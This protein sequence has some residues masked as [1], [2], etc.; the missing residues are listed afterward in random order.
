MTRQDMVE[1]LIALSDEAAQRQFLRD[2]PSL[3]NDQV[4]AALKEQAD[5][6]IRADL[7]R[8]LQVADL[9]LYLGELSGNPLHRALGL[10]AM[11][12]ARSFGG[13]GEYEYAVQLL[14]EAT[15]IY[16][17]SNLP[18][19]EA[20]TQ[21]GKIWSLALLGRYDEAFATGQWASQIL[22]EHEEWL[23]LAKMTSNLGMI[24]YRLGQD[25]EALAMFDKAKALYERLGPEEAAERALARVEQ[26]RSMALRNLGQFD[27][28]VQTSQAALDMLTRTGQSADAA[29]ARQNLGITYFVLG[30]YNEALELLDQARDF[31]IADGR[32]R[33]AILIELFTSDCLLQIRRFDDVLAKCRQVR[34]RFSELGTRF[35]V[36]QAV[37]NEALAHA[38]LGQ[39]AE[40][41]A[42][43]DQARVLFEEEGNDVWVALVD[44]EAAALLCHQGQPGQGLRSAQS[45]ARVF[46]AH[47]LPTERARAYL[48][49]AQAFAALEERDRARELV[50]ESLA[51]IEG[52]DMPSLT[53]QCH[54]LLGNLAAGVRDAQQALEEYDQAIR[55]LERLRG[56][57]MVE[58]R[59]DFL[60]DKEAIYE[61]VVGLCLDLDMPQRSLEYAE[62]AKSRALLDLLTYRLDLGIRARR[63]EDHPLVEELVRLR[64]E[65][66]RLYRRWE[67]NEEQRVRGQITPDQGPGE[68]KQDV[69]ALEK[70]IT[71]LWH[72]L[73]VHNADYA[74]DAALW[75]VRT[76]PIQ[77]YLSPE[78]VLIEYFCVHGEFVAFTVTQDSVRAW[79]L[80][81][82]LAHIQQLVRLLWLNLRAVP[83]GDAN[84]AASLEANARGL[85][86]NLY[87]SLLAPLEKVLAQYAQWIV[88]PHGPLH[89]LPFHALHDGEAYV[90]ERHE[91]SYL[92]GASMLRY[93]REVQPAPSGT[94]VLGCSYEGRLPYTVHEARAIAAVLGER[95]CL[96]GEA[97]LDRLRSDAGACRALHLATHGEFRP[98]NPL[99][100]GLALADGWLTTLDIFNLRLRASL[101]TLSACQSGQS[102]VGGGDELQG[103]MRAFLYAG[104]ASLV[105]SLWAVEDRSTAQL[106]ET[107]Y[108]RLAEGWSKGAALR[109]AQRQF[110][111]DGSNQSDATL[112]HRGH[113]F[114]WAP[115]FLVGDTR[116]L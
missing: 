50:S 113:P 76:E 78:M 72:R 89:Y 56:R 34:E 83:Q 104:A 92:P 53:H 29:R 28:S 71:T 21:I 2:H 108:H 99:F 109:Y 73:L 63:Q 65:R 11:A 44:L 67:G 114:F 94:F 43:L 8:T 42:S 57:L 66:D 100:S 111:Q 27:A 115:F 32:H 3:L 41:L 7:G 74:R 103:L 9:I 69:M 6:L 19:N 16:R 23:L 112:T 30:R 33:D 91:V 93:C 18:V 37:L 105:L 90:L 22:E 14:D 68:A 82:K 17:S 45:A 1:Q 62:R 77:P 97:T 48:V 106:M 35:E 60:V 4:A 86:Q 39:Y 36:G 98:D 52:Q 96:E 59:A 31:F 80:P 107:F 25:S 75:Q 95:P 101:V 51:L 13:L 54:H 84:Q 47:G 87:R 46:E 26:N 24:H 10:L 81:A 55:E 61:D 12:H 40:G 70:Q 20:R 116:P 15:E 88:V 85:L 110:I 64:S 38:G 5:Q 102:Q 58:F 79:R 49:A